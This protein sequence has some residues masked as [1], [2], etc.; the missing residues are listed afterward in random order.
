[1]ATTKTKPTKKVSRKARRRNLWVV[2]SGRMKQYGDMAIEAPGQIIRRG[3]MRND[4]KLLDIGYVRPV[5]VHEDFK[6]CRS[7][8][9]MFL[10]T[11]T[12]GPYKNHLDRARHDE[13]GANLDTGIT[14]TDGRV[15]ED[16]Q[17][18][19]DG[20]SNWD[21]EPEGAAPPTKETAAA[22]TVD[23]RDRR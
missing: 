20:G 12:A 18:N 14:G 2:E 15:S 23:I 10:G 9:Q 3:Y 21:L 22:V 1:M 4:V 8:G 7:C 6:K 13:A 16:A 17:S 11:A 5:D 19:P